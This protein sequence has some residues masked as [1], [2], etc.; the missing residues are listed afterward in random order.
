M[1]RRLR[2]IDIVSLIFAAIP[3]LVGLWGL[4]AR[5]RHCGILWD[6][7][8]TLPIGTAFMCSRFCHSRW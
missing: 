4:L 6:L 3:T 2:G 8:V 5:A 7:R 1:E